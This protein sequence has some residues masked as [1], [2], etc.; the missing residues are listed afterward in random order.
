ME[1]LEPRKLLS[2]VPVSFN[3][4]CGNL[5]V[6]GSG[7]DD[8]A[9]VRQVV[10]PLSNLLVFTLNG[11]KPFSVPTDRVKNI[12]FD[13]RGGNDKVE[14]NPIASGCLCTMTVCTGDGCDEVRMAAITAKSV[15]VGLGNGKDLY[16]TTG[17]LIPSLTVDG[18]NGDDIIDNS[19]GLGKALLKAGAGNDV[20]Y[21]GVEGCPNTIWAQGDKRYNHDTLWI[22]GNDRICVDS[23]D[24]VNFHPAM[25][26]L[27][28]C[29]TFKDG[30]L[31]ID[32]EKVDSAT[33]VPGPAE[34][35][36]TWKIGSG[37]WTWTFDD[38]ACVTILGTPCDDVISVAGLGVPA[39]LDGRA[40]NDLLIGGN[41]DD[42]LIGGPGNDVVRGGRGA[43]RAELVDGCFDNDSFVDFCPAEGDILHDDAPPPPPQSK[44]EPADCQ[45]D[46]AGAW[47]L[48]RGNCVAIHCAPG[49]FPGEIY[50]Q[51]V[52]DAGLPSA[53][54]PTLHFLNSSIRVEVP[55]LAAFSID[56]GLEAQ[57]EAAGYL[58]QVVIVTA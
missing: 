55:S 58:L 52:I 56:A 36:V 29:W 22:K 40:G 47:W 53:L 27:P 5:V 11:G 57:I 24:C 18:G 25:P 33:W 46:Q 43:D 54:E 19:A 8:V 23:T 16:V 34:M 28:P 49:P 13:M 3:P 6:T 45:Y 38:L 7:Q 15:F 42:V 17:P 1:S 26:A 9:C 30:K 48:L 12:K 50:Y 51:P 2:V 21:A 20:V 35:T 14:V 37:C 32:L 31:V 10:T 4:R 44:I 39:T 41:C